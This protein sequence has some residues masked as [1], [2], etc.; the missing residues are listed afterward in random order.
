MVLDHTV[1]RSSGNTYS[2]IQTVKGGRRAYERRH[3]GVTKSENAVDMSAT[4][5]PSHATEKTNKQRNSKDIYNKKIRFIFPS[6]ATMA[7][8]DIFPC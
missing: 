6:R 2:R 7:C 3:V 4:S 5:S 8:G 1:S